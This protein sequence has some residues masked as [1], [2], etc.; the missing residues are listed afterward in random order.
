MLTVVLCAVF[1]GL[2]YLLAIDVARWIIVGG[3]GAEIASGDML[4]AGYVA[5]VFAPCWLSL[6]F[7]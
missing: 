2:V 5:I 3:L 7:S 6:F 4:V 1:V